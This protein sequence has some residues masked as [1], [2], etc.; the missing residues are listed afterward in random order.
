MK[1][2]SWVLSKQTF[3]ACF[4]LQ[5]KKPLTISCLVTDLYFVFILFMGCRFSKGFAVQKVFKHDTFSG[6]NVFFIVFKDHGDLW[7]LEKN[8][9]LFTDLIPKFP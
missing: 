6:R 7:R 1:G 2:F 8:I 5:Q 4:S 3:Q 9:W